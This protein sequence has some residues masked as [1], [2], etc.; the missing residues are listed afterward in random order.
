MDVMKNKKSSLLCRFFTVYH[1][2]K[3]HSD[4]RSIG[5]FTEGS[6]V[7]QGSKNPGINR[8][9]RIMKVSKSYQTLST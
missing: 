8:V 2:T 6:P 9:K 4:I 1:C 5:D 7:I 3:F